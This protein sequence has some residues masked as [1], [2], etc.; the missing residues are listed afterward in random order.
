M[1]AHSACK[2]T[3]WDASKLGNFFCNG[4]NVRCVLSKA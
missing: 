4:V 3:L 1:I 2:L